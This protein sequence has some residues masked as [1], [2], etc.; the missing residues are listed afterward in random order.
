MK[1][2][3]CFT[4]ASFVKGHHVLAN[5]LG[6]SRGGLHE[7]RY[8]RAWQRLPYRQN[9]NRRASFL[10]SLQRYAI[11]SGSIVPAAPSVFARRRLGTR[12]NDAGARI[13]P[14]TSIH[15][16]VQLAVAGAT[17]PWTSGEPTD[18]RCI[19]RARIRRAGAH[20]SSLRIAMLRSILRMP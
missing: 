7:E 16:N 12:P 5:D 8:T 4:T 19:T 9:S 18:R 3:G 2:M 6:N 1:R 10:G 20:S 17:V 14:N 11:V 15:R 13:N